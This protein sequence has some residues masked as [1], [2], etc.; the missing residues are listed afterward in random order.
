MQVIGDDLPYGLPFA[1][2]IFLLED[3]DAACDVVKVPSPLNL[4]VS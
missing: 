4:L 1:K 3:V 2:T